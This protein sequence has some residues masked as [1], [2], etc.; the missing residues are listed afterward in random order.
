MCMGFWSGLE[1]QALTRRCNASCLLQH[2]ASM[3]STAAV[4][5]G[6]ELRHQ[7]L[8]FT[9]MP[10]AVVGHV[11]QL[12]MLIPCMCCS[13][14]HVALPMHLT[15]TQHFKISFMSPGP[16]SGR[17]APSAVPENHMTTGEC[18]ALFP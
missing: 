10:A 5:R 1:L 9:L 3:T 17:G 8:A 6:W 13:Q 15:S 16:S 2:A 4:R 11:P 18:P 14:V 7:G 12:S